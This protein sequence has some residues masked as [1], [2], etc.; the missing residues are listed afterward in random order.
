MR[1]KWFQVGLA[2]VSIVAVATASFVWRRPALAQFPVE[3]VEQVNY[4]NYLFENRMDHKGGVLAFQSRSLIG[5]QLTVYTDDGDASSIGGITSPFQIC[6]GDIFYIKNGALKQR[7]ID[8]GAELVISEDVTSFIAMDTKVYYLSAG[9]LFVH[10]HG[11]TRLLGKELLQFYI[12]KDWVFAIG[13]DGSLSKLEQDG[14]WTSVC[15]IQID[16]YPFWAMP[17]GD[18]LICSTA[19]A[20][21][22]IDIQT[23]DEKTLSWRDD[24]SANDRIVFI[25]D[26]AHLYVS[27]QAT[28]TDGSVVKDIEDPSNGVWSVD[29]ETLEYEQLCEAT[30]EEL[31]LFDGDLLYGVRDD[32]LFLIDTGAGTLLEVA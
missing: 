31:Y 24:A 3:F 17:M 32:T 10:E 15:T 22:I 2:I 14:G 7:I 21:Q 30:F 23:G 29:P 6:G 16:G 25:C 26:D 19:G 5:Q 28:Q 20:L 1:A 12:H 8:S 18:N 11:T 27:Y 9:A 13:Q 4:N